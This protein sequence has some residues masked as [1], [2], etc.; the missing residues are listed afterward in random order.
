MATRPHPVPT[1][2]EKQRREKR[3]ELG[4]DEAVKILEAIARD[5]DAKPYERLQAISQLERRRK[6][7]VVAKPNDNAPADPMADLDELAPRRAR[8]AS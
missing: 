5:E 2:G 3:G 1:R 8:R 7:G 4:E 6:R